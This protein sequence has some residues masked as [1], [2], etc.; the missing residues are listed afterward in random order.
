[1][2]LGGNYIR[3]V[4]KV[5]AEFRATANEVE[6]NIQHVTEPG[7]LPLTRDVTISLDDIDL[8]HFIA[9]LEALTEKLRGELPYIC[10]V[11]GE[12]LDCDGR[13]PMREKDHHHAELK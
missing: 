7:A 13:C 6:L 8:R 5:S 12:G 3:Q 1:M 2:Y 11:C 4:A 9:Q 10:D